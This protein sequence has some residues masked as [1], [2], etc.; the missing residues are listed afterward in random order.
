MVPWPSTVIRLSGIGRSSVDSQKSTACW[1]S[2]S[3]VHVGASPASSGF[4]PLYIG[5]CDLPTIWML[6][7]GFRIPDRQ[8]PDGRQVAGADHLDVAYREFETRHAE[9]KIVQAQSLLVLGRVGL[10]GDG[11]NSLAVVIHV[12]SSHHVRPVSQPMGVF[13]VARGKQKLG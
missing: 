7:I 13:V 6:P 3:S 1:A 5:P 9:V 2:L 8:H 10:F 11:Q 4:S 12:I